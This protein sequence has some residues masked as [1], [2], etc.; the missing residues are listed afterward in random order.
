MGSARL[1]HVSLYLLQDKVDSL[2]VGTR[3]IKRS[4]L[5]GTNAGNTRDWNIEMKILPTQF[6]SQFQHLLID[7]FTDTVA[8]LN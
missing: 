3:Y 8:I 7:L 4:L 5:K 2:V 6:Q 1:I